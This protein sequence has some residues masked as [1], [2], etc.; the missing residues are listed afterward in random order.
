MTERLD[1]L[2]VRE[3]NGK[4][5]FTKVG[6]AFPNRDGKGFT[7]LLHAMPASIDGQYKIM[8]RAPLPKDGDRPQRQQ[9][10]QNSA[11]PA[12]DL[13]DTVPY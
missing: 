3:S 8:L 12:D 11:W 13:D 10:S 6:A 7:V 1:A 2:S 4:S 9:A 5:F